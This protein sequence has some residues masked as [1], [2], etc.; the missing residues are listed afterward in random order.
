[1]ALAAIKEATTAS[2]RYQQTTPVSGSSLLIHPQ[3]FHPIITNPP[4]TLFWTPASSYCQQP[5]LHD[6]PH[7]SLTR[8]PIARAKTPHHSVTMLAPVTLIVLSPFVLSLSRA[9]VVSLLLDRPDRP[10]PLQ[11]CLLK[12]SM[13]SRWS[14]EMAAM[15]SLPMSPCSGRAHSPMFPP[16]L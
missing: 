11:S 6:S 10:C 16:P 15:D 4:S 7:F 14:H 12:L 1:M 13:C 2:L 8:N 3:S 5:Y 9:V